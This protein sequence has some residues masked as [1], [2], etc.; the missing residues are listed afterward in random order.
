M[1]GWQR[2]G[3]QLVWMGWQSIQVVD[4]SACVIFLLLQKI[5][6]MAKCTFWYQITWVV[7][8][9]FQ[10]A[11]EWLYV[12]YVKDYLHAS[13]TF[14]S[15]IIT[16]HYLKDIIGT[17][18]L[19]F[20]YLKS[21]GQEVHEIIKSHDVQAVCNIFTAYSSAIFVIYWVW[22]KKHPLQKSHYFQNN[23]IFFGELFRGYLWDILPL[24]LKFLAFLH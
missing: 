5:Q 22:P 20:P 16:A 13:G 7:L 10:K 18:G 4:A 23:L 8:D 12:L 21:V 17:G 24:V 19:C 15:Q 14:E 2:W 11:V 1:V 6:K 9:K 3:R